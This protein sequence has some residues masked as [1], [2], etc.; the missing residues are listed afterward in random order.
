MRHLHGHKKLSRPTD[1]RLALLKGLS[2]NLIEHGEIMT[3]K[4]KAKALARFMQ[5]IVGLARKGDV[6]SLRE[7]RKQIDSRVL[8]RKLTSE[9]VP[10]L[11]SGPGGEVSVINAGKRRGDGA[12]VA[13]VTFNLSE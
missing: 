3:S 2:K 1:Q 8:I 13:V 10:K 7:I 6:S 11:S 4:A 12:E 9:I 5:K